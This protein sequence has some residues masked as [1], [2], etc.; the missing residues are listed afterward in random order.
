[1]VPRET[2]KIGGQFSGYNN[3]VVILPPLNPQDINSCHVI[4]NKEFR[5][6]KTK[7]QIRCMLTTNEFLK[8]IFKKDIY[9]S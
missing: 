9:F 3:S 1:M 8:K 5:D 6:A 4:Q 7:S 2:K